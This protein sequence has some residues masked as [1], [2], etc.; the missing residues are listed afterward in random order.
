MQN[1]KLRTKN[2]KLKPNSGFTL[3]EIIVAVG[4]FSMA[5]S[6]ILSAMLSMT[7]AQRKAI[8][9]QSAEDNLRFAIEAMSR[10][11]RTGNTYDCNNAGNG[12]PSNCNGG[13]NSLAFVSAKGNRIIYRWNSLDYTIEKS[14]DDGGAYYPITS[15]DIKIEMLRFYVFGA[16]QD[17]EQPRVLISIRATAQDLKSKVQSQFNIQTTIAQRELDS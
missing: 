3:F 5:I 11:I 1:A 10:E 7:E 12:M 6:V 8:T 2:Y 15:S 4:V 16:G 9:L 14:V 13:G 17:Q